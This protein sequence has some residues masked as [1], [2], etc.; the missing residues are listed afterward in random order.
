MWTNAP[1][2]TRPVSRARRARL[3]VEME[4]L[5][6]STGVTVIAIDQHHRRRGGKG[7]R[8]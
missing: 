2:S 5:E 4:D 8:H 6:L 3:F 1:R 7:L